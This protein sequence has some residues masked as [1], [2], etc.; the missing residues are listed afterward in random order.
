MTVLRATT[1]SLQTIDTAEK[2]AE[3][4]PGRPMRTVCEMGHCKL[5]NANCK[6]Q[7]ASFFLPFALCSQYFAEVQQ[8]LTPKHSSRE[9][10]VT[11]V[12]RV[13]KSKRR[14][15]YAASAARGW[16]HGRKM[17]GRARYFLSG[18]ISDS[19]ATILL[20]SLSFSSPFLKAR[21][22]FTF[23]DL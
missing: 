16:F 3:A 15:G 22:T 9:K 20:T 12:R 5:Q 18:K 4:L 1:S 7:N 2:F 11:A 14:R 13:L 10:S 23:L 6:R 8:R 17:Q 19:S 21:L